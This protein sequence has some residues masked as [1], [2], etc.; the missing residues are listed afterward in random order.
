MHTAHTANNTIQCIYPF[1]SEWFAV[2]LPADRVNTLSLY[3]HLKINGMKIFKRLTIAIAIIVLLVSAVAGYVQLAL[4]DVGDAPELKLERSPERVER[5]R[6]LAHSV[7]ICM[8]CHSS[9]D[10][11]VFAGPMKPEG[12]GAGGERFGPE[13]G[14]PGTFYSPNITPY[15]L[16]DWT[17]GDLF[18]AITTGVNKHGGALFPL[19]PY[20]RFGSMDVEDIY[21]VMAY[22][23]SLPAVP[24]EVPVS[25][26]DFPVN[27]LINTMPQKANFT[28]RPDTSD[29]VKYGAYIVNAAGC[30]DCHRKVDKNGKTI[31]GTE[32]GG[33]MEF[34]QPAGVIRSANITPD[35]E[36]GIGSWTAE[37]LIQRFKAY[38]DSSY[39]P[40]RLSPDEL[41]SPM[42]WTMY[43]TM[44]DLDLKAIYTYLK[45][46]KPIN[47]KVERTGK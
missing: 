43:A 20:L 33:G 35:K 2:V 12:I 9:R 40:R 36:T 30:I 10:W 24:S 16:A 27:F 5:G 19:M 46:L 37:M 6:Y 8:D 21:D 13:M 4:P 38:T 31:P 14:F 45:S 3:C 44:T 42:P 41:N 7:M 15:A 47:Y 26:P 28:T 25:K 11:T 23:R 34:R 29:L 22:I 39:Q 18:R 1:C 17:D 32:F